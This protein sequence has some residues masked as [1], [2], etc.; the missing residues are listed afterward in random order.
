VAVLITVGPSASEPSLFRAKSTVTMTLTLRPTQQ[1]YSWRM[2]RAASGPSP[3]RQGLLACRV[4]RMTHSQEARHD[5]GNCPF[6]RCPPYAARC[7]AGIKAGGSRWRKAAEASARRR[8]PVI[9]AQI[10]R[11]SNEVEPHLVAGGPL[12]KEVVVALARHLGEPSVRRRGG[13]RMVVDPPVGHRVRRGS[14][15][16]GRW[17]RG[18][19]GSP[20]SIPSCVKKT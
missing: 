8:W 2:I 10:V 14:R 19:C 4:S 11:Q 3:A 16:R 12:T 6:Y 9:R 5:Y 1:A 7:H 13:G 15:A 20:W 17:G 18:E